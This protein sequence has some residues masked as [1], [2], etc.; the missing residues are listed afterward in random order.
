[1]KL[2]NKSA[3]ILC[4]SQVTLVANFAKKSVRKYYAVK[5]AMRQCP[6]LNKKIDKKRLSYQSDQRGEISSRLFIL[7][8]GY[9]Q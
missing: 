7:S 8:D 6:H 3:D 2:L 5:F 4:I 1:M 9:T